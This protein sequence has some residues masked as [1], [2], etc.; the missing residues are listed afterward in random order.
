MLS[1]KR[2][3]LDKAVYHLEVTR[4]LP[5]VILWT[6]QQSVHNNN[7]LESCT[8][9]PQEPTLEPDMASNFNYYQ[10]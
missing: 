2:L 7:Q 5:A 4:L 6:R 9:C 3:N 8:N 10:R 1:K